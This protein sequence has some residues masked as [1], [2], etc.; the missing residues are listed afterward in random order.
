M[1]TILSQL[2]AYTHKK[3]MFMDMYITTVYR[4]M[5]RFVYMHILTISHNVIARCVLDLVASC[6]GIWPVVV[7]Y[8][9]TRCTKFQYRWARPHNLSRPGVSTHHVL[10][11]TPDSQKQDEDT[12]M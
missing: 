2:P 11:D 8:I 4:F 5:Y 6:D 10:C 7:P 12:I 9:N 1:A 3:Y